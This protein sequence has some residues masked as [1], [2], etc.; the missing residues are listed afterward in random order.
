MKE[1]EAQ[2]EDPGC[3]CGHPLCPVIHDFLREANKVFLEKYLHHVMA[4]I[5]DSCLEV[6]HDSINESYWK[7][8]V[9]HAHILGLE[10]LLEDLKQ[11]RA[12]I[13]GVSHDGG[14]K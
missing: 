2:Q 10:S 1:N 14:Q 13:L 5:R 12:R 9:N 7:I 3:D 6:M 4:R 8:D 11:E